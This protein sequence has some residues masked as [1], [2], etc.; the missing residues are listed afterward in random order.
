MADEQDD[1]FT[2][3]Y[4]SFATFKN[5]ML[6]L[7]PDALPPRID[8]S[9]MVG[10][11]GGTQTHL[12]QALRSFTLIGEGNQVREPFIRMAGGE[13]AFADAMRAILRHF[14]AAQVELAE[15]QATTAQLI[16]SFEPSGYS[17]STLRKAMTFFLHAARDCGMPLSPHFRAP[18]VSTGTRPRRA[19]KAKPKPPPPAAAAETPAAESHSIRLRSGGVVT[20]SCSTEFLAL[21]REDR[22]FLFGLVDALR[23][24]EAINRTDGSAQGDA[25]AGGAHEEGIA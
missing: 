9:L 17:G 24:Y 3:P 11:A 1:A 10:M 4:I 8:R 22:D 14:Y 13:A 23:D 25:A 15:Q 18:S 20:L 2:Y 16:E 21:T 5:F 19:A 12:L 7:D 6:G